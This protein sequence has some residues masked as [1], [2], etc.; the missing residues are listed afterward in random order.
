MPNIKRPETKSET[1]WKAEVEQGLVAMIQGLFQFKD[2][3]DVLQPVKGY[4]RDPAEVLKTEIFPCITIYN[5]FDRENIYRR[6]YERDMKIVGKD[7]D[8]KKVFM[9]KPP[10]PYDAFYQVDFWTLSNRQMNDLTLMWLDMCGR[11]F[12]LDC[13]DA[14]DNLRNIYCGQVGHLKKADYIQQE[15]N[16]RVFHS[17]IDYRI[18]VEIYERKLYDV[19]MVTDIEINTYMLADLKN[20]FKKGD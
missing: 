16:V 7:Y 8:T 10:A 15:N 6:E 11:F 14:S 20:K 9:E 5:T 19:P 1:I 13:K 12:N 2:I 18:W 4:V 3:N 17:I